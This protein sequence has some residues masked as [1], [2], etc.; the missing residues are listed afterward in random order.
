MSASAIE[1]P[2]DEFTQYP[3]L[4]RKGMSDFHRKQ[5]IIVMAYRDKMANTKV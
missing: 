3:A 4:I 1:R 5:L 2:L